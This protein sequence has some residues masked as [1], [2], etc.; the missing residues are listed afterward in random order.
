MQV[1]IPGV[2]ANMCEQGP[3]PLQAGVPAIFDIEVP[4]PS[5]APVS[6]TTITLKVTGDDG[7]EVC[8][9]APVIFT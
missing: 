4:V 2:N 9:K 3:C 7:L 1:P 5:I 6:K 8:A